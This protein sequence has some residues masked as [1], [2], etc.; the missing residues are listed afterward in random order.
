MD[1]DTVLAGL[2]NLGDY[3]CAF[4]AVG[5]VEFC[6]LSEGIF[7]GDIGVQNKEG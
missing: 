6:K 5:F 4:F 7:A 2:F 3:D 1:H